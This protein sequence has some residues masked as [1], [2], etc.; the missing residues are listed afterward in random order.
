MFVMTAISYPLDNQNEQDVF[1]FLMTVEMC[2]IYVS[3]EILKCG[4]YVTS[5]SC[6][7]DVSRSLEKINCIH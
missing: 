3:K 1:S 4:F 7:G 6:G 5:Q 2:K